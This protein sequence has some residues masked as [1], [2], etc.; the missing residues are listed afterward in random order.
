MFDNAIDP[1]TLPR[2]TVILQP[3]WNYVVKRSRVRQ[4]RQ[5]YNG[6]KIAAPL[7]HAMV[8]TW[9]SCLELPIQRLFIGLCAQKGL[10]MYDDAHDT[11][12]HAPAPPRTHN[13]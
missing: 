10:C 5:C 1:Y 4:S 9:S 2:N 6:S 11:Y 13:R 12:A 7:L 8:S 3:H